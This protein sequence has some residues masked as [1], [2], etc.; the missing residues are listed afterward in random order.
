MLDATATIH[1]T[2]LELHRRDTDC[3]HRRHVSGDSLLE[4]RVAWG[5][6]GKRNGAAVFGQIDRFWPT[7]RHIRLCGVIDPTG[8]TNLVPVDHRSGLWHEPR[9]YRGEDSLRAT[10]IFGGEVDFI[11]I[12]SFCFPILMQG[13]E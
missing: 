13:D 1:R 11:E 2:N 9:A 10:E 3:F 4:G 5:L 12:E 8:T 7:F 6:K